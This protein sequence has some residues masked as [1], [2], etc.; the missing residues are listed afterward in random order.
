MHRPGVMAPPDLYD[1]PA[2]PGTMSPSPAAAQPFKPKVFLWSVA[3]VLAAA[4]LLLEL[5]AG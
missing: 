4:E 3:G 1:Q 5:A 2:R